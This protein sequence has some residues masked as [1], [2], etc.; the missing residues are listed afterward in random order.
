MDIQYQSLGW[1]N[2]N[3]DGTTE[4]KIEKRNN[5]GYD[6]NLHTHICS[7]VYPAVKDS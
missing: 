2:N 6:P 1:Y 3:N 4:T 5:L 7:N